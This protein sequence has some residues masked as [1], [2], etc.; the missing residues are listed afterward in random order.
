MKVSDAPFQSSFAGTLR[1]N[2]QITQSVNYSHFIALTYSPGDQLKIIVDYNIA[3][4]SI[5]N[6]D[7]HLIF[8]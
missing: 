2:P 5:E 8:N 3:D 4:P 7:S 1:G 6:L